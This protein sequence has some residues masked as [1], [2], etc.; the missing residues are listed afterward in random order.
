MIQ[1]HKGLVRPANGFVTDR[2][3]TKDSESTYPVTKLI[4]CDAEGSRDQVVECLTDTMTI[5][6][7]DVS[8]CFVQWKFFNILK[9]SNQTKRD[10]TGHCLTRSRFTGKETN[11]KQIRTYEMIFYL[12]LVG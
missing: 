4:S 1:K 7:T 11:I 3:R 12:F 5:N 8:V 9:T 10:I 6:P 2:K